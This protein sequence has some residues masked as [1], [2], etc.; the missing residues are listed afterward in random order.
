MKRLGIK[1]AILGLFAS[2]NVFAMDVDLKES[3][4][5][6]TG[7]KV[8]GSSHT[9]EIKIKN[10]DIKVK[11]N[12]PVSATIVMDM[13][14]ITNTDLKDKSF[15]KKLVEHLT[16]ADFFDVQKFSTSTLNITNI[17][18]ASDKF[19]LL[20]GKLKIKGVE[21]PVKLKASVVKENKDMKQVSVDFTFDRTNWGIKYGSGSFF[22][23][24]GDKMISDEVNLK[25]NLT[26]KKPSKVAAK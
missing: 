9:G 21:K 25:V 13:K 4:A 5:V 16:S 3:K 22:K 20:S 1:I 23:G 17:Q 8:V 19:Y 24:L 2:F 18:K 12:E 10:A 14:S 7:T 26:I 11:N 15:N 6:W